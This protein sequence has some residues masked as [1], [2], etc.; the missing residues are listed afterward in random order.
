[1]TILFDWPDDSAGQSK[2]RGQ[3]RVVNS[4]HRMLCANDAM[5]MNTW[6]NR[7]GGNA[8][9]ASASPAL[10]H[11]PTVTLLDYAS[12]DDSFVLAQPIPRGAS[13]T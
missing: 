1:M 11:E 7:C 13:P 4:V 12:K 8:G 3:S 9:S 6:A 10:T 5:T 2:V